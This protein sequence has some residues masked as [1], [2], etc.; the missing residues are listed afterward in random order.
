MLRAYL[1]TYLFFLF[2]P[3]AM[4]VLFSFHS[5]PGLVFPMEGFSLRWYSELFANGNFVASLWNSVKVGIFTS[6]VTT[7][8]GTLAALALIRM[9]GS[10]RRVFELLNFMPIGL[11][12]LFL[13][14]ALVTLFAEIGLPRSLVTVTI[15]HVLF[16]LP[17]FVETMRSRITYFDAS[18]EEAAR[19]L[20]ASQFQTFRLVTIPILLPTIVGAAILTF[21]LSFD[22]FIITVFVSGNDT[23]LPLF[24]WSML[25]RTVDPSINAA[26]VLALALSILVLAAGGLSMWMQR[27]RAVAARVAELEGE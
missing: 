14:I 13:G 24:I 5:T 1:S 7:I 4:I 15:A 27:K 9:R 22:E 26:S 19:D 6:I 21:A 23:T 16:T 18:L 8:L 25:R 2:A 12:G 11:P 20:G 17:F 10:F 3:I